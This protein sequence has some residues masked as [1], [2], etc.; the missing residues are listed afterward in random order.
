MEHPARSGP[1]AVL[2]VPSIRPHPLRHRHGEGAPR[3]LVAMKFGGTSVADAGCIQ[4]VTEIVREYVQDYRVLTVVSAMA[5]VTD[6]LIEAA[7]QSANEHT[8]RVRQIFEDL[9]QRHEIASGGLIAVSKRKQLYERI[10]EC[11]QQGLR[12][13]EET[14]R[15]RK[16]TPR[17][18]DFIASL[19]ERLCA[20]IVSAALKENGVTS[21]DVDGRECLITDSRHGAAK[22]LREPTR[23]CC[24]RRLHPI[25]QA[26]AVPVVTGFLGSTK[27]GIL[28]TLGRGG[29][30]YTATILADA[31]DAHQVIIWT[32]VDGVLTSDPHFVMEARTI[33]HLSY[34]EAVALAHFGA[35]VLH[36][37]TLDPV[38]QRGIP[39]WVRNTFAPQGPG[40]EISR[41]ESGSS[42]VTALAAT[43]DVGLITI[44]VCV[45]EKLTTAVRR[46]CTA[47]KKARVDAL[48]N[49]TRCPSLEFCIAVR[50][51]LAERATNSLQKEFGATESQESLGKITLETGIS[52]VTVVGKNTRYC[53]NQSE[54]AFAA[55]S[56][57]GLRVLGSTEQNSDPVFS[58]VVK[59]AEM[60]K[61]LRVLHAELELDKTPG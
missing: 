20:P 14:S 47:L 18:R 16:L 45:I 28:T 22:P 51:S 15:V 21:E 46:S 9:R 59:Q 43:R 4:K 19:G 7:E 25:L 40:T 61:V 30:D 12:A 34:W 23:A 6:L 3:P 32:D 35:K 10:D 27:E 8:P 42:S 37:K 29:S 53:S 41:G 44:S 38:V 49:W 11:F 31:L 50:S 17:A 57:E 60:E 54:R 48:L 56:R 33:P 13:C 36:P 5:G 1:H 2:P 55:L 24:A 39:V 52:L 58:F 26:G